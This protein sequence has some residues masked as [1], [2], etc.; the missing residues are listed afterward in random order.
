MADSCGLY[1]ANKIKALPAYLLDTA[2]EKF[3]EIPQA[4]RTG[5]ATF[6]AVRDALA[7][8]YVDD[9]HAYA[10]ATKL[11][12]HSLEP[13]ETVFQFSNALLKLAQGAYGQAQVAEL[14]NTVLKD[15]FLQGL[16][17][18]VSSRLYVEYPR[19][20][21][22]AVSAAQRVSDASAQCSPMSTNLCATSSE[23]EASQ[24]TPTSDALVL[25]VL[26]QNSQLMKA[27]T[28]PFQQKQAASYQFPSEFPNQLS[29]R[30]RP[31]CNYCNRWGH[32][33]GNCYDRQRDQQ[34][35]G[36][37][38]FPCFPGPRASQ[39]SAFRPFGG[40]SSFRSPPRWNQSNFG[41]PN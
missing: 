7:A 5:W 3:Y 27:A 8:I 38:R 24:S 41:R 26:K 11:L 28:R 12:R 31:Q 13:N 6:Q 18:H 16:P 40:Y 22:E 39:P 35:M 15:I 1:E 21:Q 34:F 10:S 25:A 14:H 37:F 23:V 29:T 20:W 33:W 30:M 4:T 19:T 17:G 32:H 36:Q 9:S 2:A